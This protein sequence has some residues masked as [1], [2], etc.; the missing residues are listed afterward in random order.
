MQ[1]LLIIGFNLF[2]GFIR[3]GIDNFAHI[4]GLLGG[5]LAALAL[6]LYGERVPKARRIAVIAGMACL[7]YTSRCV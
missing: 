3:T 4:G 2:Y 1:V 5:F 7:L 6:G